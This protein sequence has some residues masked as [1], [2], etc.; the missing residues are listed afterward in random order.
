[1]LMKSKKGLIM[2]VANE[3]SIA[4]G[5]AKSIYDQGGSLAFTYQGD[6]LK[7]RVAPL[8]ESVDSNILIPCDVSDRNSMEEA[9]ET[10]KNKWGSIDFLVHA[11]GYSSKDELRGKYVETSSENFDQT[12]HIS[13][14]SFTEACRLAKPLMKNGGSII[15]LTYYG[16]EQ[17][18]PHYN[19]M[20]VAKAALEALEA[21]LLYHDRLYFEEDN[22]AISDAEYD[23]L[24]RRNK[25]IEARFP[26]LV[27]P[28]S[29][30]L[31]VGSTPVGRFPKAT[32]LKPMLSLENAFQEADLE[33]FL[34]R[35]K[36]LL[37][38][39]ATDEITM[40]AEPKI[41][42]LSLAITYENGA[43]V[44]AATRGDGVIGEEITKN[45][46]TIPS[47]PHKIPADVPSVIEIRGEVYIEKKDFYQLNAHRTQNDETL[48]ANPR[49]AAAGSL[50][51]LD[52]KITATR[53][54]KFFAYSTVSNQALTSTQNELLNRLGLWGFQV[55]Q[56]RQL[57]HN[58]KE[59]QA[60][61][62]TLSRKRE[63]LPYEIDGIVFKVNNFDMQERLGFVS[64]AP[65]WAIA[66]KFPAEQI[67]TRIKDIKI[68]VGRT[69]VLT[70]IAEL[71][72]VNVGGVTVS[73]AT[74]HNQD[75]IKRK[76]I[77]KGD[78]VL[79]QRAGDVIPQ[80]IKSFGAE[81]PRAAAFQFP[82][83]CPIC[84]SHVVKEK[85]EVALRCSGGLTCPAQALE[86]LKHFVSKH[87]FNIDG[88][89]GRRI[90]D[91]WEKNL[92]KAP[93]DIFTLEKRNQSNL[94]RL[95]NYPGWG[96]QSVQNL[97]QIIEA[98]RHVTLDRLIYALGIRHIGR[99]SAKVLANHYKKFN[100]WWQAA[101]TAHEDA[102]IYEEL[103]SL[104]G[105]GS[106]V[107]TSIINFATEE[108]NKLEVEQLVQHLF[109]Q[110]VLSSQVLKDSFLKDKTIVFTGTLEH[111][112]REEAEEKATQMGAK[113]TKSVSKNTDYVVY[114][115][116]TGSKLEKAQ[117]LGVA[118]L[119]EEEWLKKLA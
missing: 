9:F 111:F 74:L 40:M 20:G 42:G 37:A 33:G 67:K 89:G 108:K 50:R 3:R 14:Y 83:H 11:I 117:A 8:A 45:I 116:D 47:I 73:R 86:S 61:F 84:N 71:E 75:E 24:A 80:I 48:F 87:A 96:I 25:E 30:T 95:E 101:Q 36:K 102:S 104:E 5:I 54:L 76:D 64:R 46:L 93:S 19:V 115:R 32:H 59:M 110:E 106:I 88:L 62:E 112:S 43:L 92:V 85:D 13:C 51:Q 22:P 118:T 100:T 90:D 28:K 82:T 72:P 97:F 69:G 119:T 77:R 70:P 21:E 103:T 23:A 31:R 107:A 6:A 16:A 18:M 65:R 7:K 52:E 38:L 56:E 4:W 109:I 41:D 98:Q 63:Q 10:I 78:I 12:M 113:V 17:V 55:N 44:R 57:C 105:I 68:N 114:G 1:M 49:N 53:P 79:V 27:R 39:S 15:T 26:H 29:R 2:G 66:Q 81:G 99:V 58:L 35:C 94:T 34:S 60:Y 91:L